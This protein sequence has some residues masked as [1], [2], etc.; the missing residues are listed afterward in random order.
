MDSPV[1]YLRQSNFGAVRSLKHN[2]DPIWA[3]EGNTMRTANTL[4]SFAGAVGDTINFNAFNFRILGSSIPTLLE[5]GKSYNHVSVT[6]PAEKQEALVFF[7]STMENKVAFLKFC[8]K[9]NG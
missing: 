2:R 9:E 6:L 4:I 5:R 8:R 7:M 3:H 1:D